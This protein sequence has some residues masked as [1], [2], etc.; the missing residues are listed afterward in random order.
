MWKVYSDKCNHK[1]KNFQ[2]I[3]TNHYN[4]MQILTP[5]LVKGFICCK[6]N[7]KEN[8]WHFLIECKVFDS[9]IKKYLLKKYQKTITNLIY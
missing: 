8:T 4:K 7:T 9:A 6:T 1:I 3:F 5:E 2:F